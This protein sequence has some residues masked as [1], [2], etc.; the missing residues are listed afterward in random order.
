MAGNADDE[1][2]YRRESMA[3]F[4]HEIRTPLTAIRMVLDLAERERDDDR[5]VLDGELAAMLSASIDDLQ[6]LTDDLQ[7]VSRLERGKVRLASGPSELAPVVEAAREIV[8]A[9][10][11]LAADVPEGVSGAWDARQLARA[12]ADFATTAN[13]VGDGSGVVA[14]TYKAAEANGGVLRITSGTPGDKER[15]IGAD[16]G[17]G[18]FRARLVMLAM[19]GTVQWQRHERFFEVTL[20]LP[21]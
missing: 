14:V 15:G 2:Q 20:Q 17:F 16:A 9:Q 1:E 12:L 10:I 8:G 11:T 21:T 3:A 6:H 5:L 13:R 7:E 18:F 19:G 4:A